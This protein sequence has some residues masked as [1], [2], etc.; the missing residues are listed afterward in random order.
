MLNR[1]KFLF[2]INSVDQTLCNWLSATDA[3][4][5]R[6]D[7]LVEQREHRSMAP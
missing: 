5:P 6:R 7:N 2:G 1:A 4:L 3:S